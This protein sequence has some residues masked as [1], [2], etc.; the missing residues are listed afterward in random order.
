LKIEVFD[1]EEDA[2]RKIRA[3]RPDGSVCEPGEIGELYMLPES[4]QGSTYRYKG[5]EATA[6]ADGWETVGD[7]GTLDEDG[8][9]YLADRKTDMIVTGG[10]NVYPAEVEAALDAHPA[11]RS[12][13]VIGLPDDDLG[14]RIHAI[15]DAPEPVKE[16]ELREYN[17]ALEGDADANVNARR[18]TNVGTF[19]AYVFNYLQHHPQINQDLTLLVRQRD[20]TPDGL[21]LEIYAFTSDT[22]WAAYEG[23]QSDVFDHVIAIVPEFGLRLYQSPSS[24]DV[25]SVGLELVRAGTAPDR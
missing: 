1:S 8:Y 15:V 5:A 12:S 6:T 23:I 2:L 11:V 18:L 7:L 9:L 25:R 22:G 13:A 4:G 14:Q 20:P 10:A 21:P 24:A 3:L 19:R 16:D 17:A